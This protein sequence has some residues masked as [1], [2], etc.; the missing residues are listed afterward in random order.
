MPVE[1]NKKRVTFRFHAPGADEVYLLGAFND[2]DSLP[3]K[4][5]KNGNWSTTVALAA[6]IYEYRFVAWGD[7]HQSGEPI[8]TEFGEHNCLICL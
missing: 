4:Q 3:L 8:P 1:I 6:G 7:D 2:W 5:Q